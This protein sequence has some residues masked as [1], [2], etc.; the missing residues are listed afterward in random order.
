[1]KEVLNEQLE[2]DSWLK[3]RDN[4]EILKERNIDGLWKADE[5]SSAPKN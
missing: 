3:T 2:Y 1:M 4:L 5:Y